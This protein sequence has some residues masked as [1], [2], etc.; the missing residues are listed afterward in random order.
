MVEVECR[1]DDCTGASNMSNKS[2]EH[3]TGQTALDGPARDHIHLLVVNGPY[4]GWCF[5]GAVDG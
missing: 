5:N 3:M 1:L 2:W 4:N